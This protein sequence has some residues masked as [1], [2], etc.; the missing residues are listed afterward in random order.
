VPLDPDALARRAIAQAAADVS[1]LDRLRERSAHVLERLRETS[2]VRLAAAGGVIVLAF[3]FLMFGRAGAGL[4]AA[5]AFP[6]DATRECQSNELDLRVTKWEPDG[7]DRVASVEMHNIGAMACLV[8][9]LP[10]PW[11]VQ[12]PQLPMLIGT[13]ISGTLIRIGP[14]D[15]LRTTVHVRN[16]CGPDP[17]APVTLAFRRTTTVFMAQPLSGADVSGVPPCGGVAASPNDISMQPWSY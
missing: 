9:N 3:A 4:P 6:T 10:E 8:D 2:P 17:K 5:T 16:Y 14:G 13:D 11:L 1:A 12:A 15:T 7:N